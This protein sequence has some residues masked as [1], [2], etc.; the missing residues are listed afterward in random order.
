M[1]DTSSGLA[2]PADVGEQFSEGKDTPE[3]QTGQRAESL[4]GSRRR[5]RCRGELGAG[6]APPEPCQRAGTGQWAAGAGHCP[7]TGA[8]GAEAL[9]PAPRPSPQSVSHLF[10]FC[11]P[12]QLHRVGEMPA[13]PILYAPRKSRSFFGKTLG[14]SWGLRTYPGPCHPGAA[15]VAV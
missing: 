6:L 7:A 14:H 15:S 11:P 10:P 5:T 2:S 12:S 8:P 9:C 13:L 4:S 1:A 3:A